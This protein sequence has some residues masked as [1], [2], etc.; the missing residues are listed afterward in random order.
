[1]KLRKFPVFSDTGNEYA[2]TLYKPEYLYGMAAKVYVKE[3]RLFGLL[4]FRKVDDGTWFGT[5][6]WGYD[7]KAM[8][9]RAVN[10]CEKEQAEKAQRTLDK[11][12]G[13]RDF[14]KWDG[15]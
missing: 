2:V 1:M 13:L 4:K 6:E 11:D 3:S 14:E 12:A 10:R 15:K 7:Y 8:A 9:K 5:E